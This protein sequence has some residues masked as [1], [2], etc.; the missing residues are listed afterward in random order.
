MI[1]CV[2]IDAASSSRRSSS[3]VLRG[4]SRRRVDVLDRDRARAV[5]GRLAGR[6]RAMAAPIVVGGTGAG[7]PGIS[8]ARPRPSALR[9]GGGALIGRSPP[10]SVGRPA[11]APGTPAPDPGSS[12]RP[13]RRRRRAGSAC[14]TTAPRTGARCAARSSCRPAVEVRAHL[15]GHLLGQVLPRI[16]HAQHD[17]FDRQP[18]VQRL[19]DQPDRALQVRQPLER[20]VLALHR[21]QH[22]VGGGQRVQRQQ[23][24][25]RRRVED[26]VVV[27][28]GGLAQRAR[29]AGA[30]GSSSVTSSI[31]APARSAL[32]GTRSRWGSSVLRMT[33]ASAGV[34]DQHVVDAAL[35]GAAARVA[36][37]R[38]GV[39]L[40][41]DVDQQDALLGGRQGGGK[42]HRRGGLPHAA[43]LIRYR[44]D[45]SHEIR[46]GLVGNTH[47][48][49]VTTGFQPPPV[50]GRAN[51]RIGE[52]FDG[53]CG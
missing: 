46:A 23:A 4:C 44:D 29:A 9:F 32:A 50:D 8:A 36:Q 34:A 45:P 24:Q 18:G 1:P 27:A 41:V 13:W 47:W 26:D 40:R 52:K 19:A 28:V 5:A 35:L 6:G 11:G 31:S 37:P 43:L 33:S 20:V 10:P 51:A 3:K 38:A 39:P 16:D 53:V 14:R 12:A 15:A 17:A 49:T 7:A 48:L 30:R 22:R 25:R 42:I 21:H 2:R